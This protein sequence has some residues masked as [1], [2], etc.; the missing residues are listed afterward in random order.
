M[1][2]G[3]PK[4]DDRLTVTGSSKVTIKSN[5]PQGSA[6]FG[7]ISVLPFKAD[8]LK[9]M[10]RNFGKLFYSLYLCVFHCVYYSVFCL[11]HP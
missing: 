3:M 5:K 9:M 7:D 6:W 11:L 4:R 10:Q 1:Q 8:G 2:Q